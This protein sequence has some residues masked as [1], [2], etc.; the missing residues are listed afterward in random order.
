M[1]MVLMYATCQGCGNQMLLIVMHSKKHLYGPRV[2]QE[3]TA[4]VVVEKLC[5]IDPVHCSNN[6]VIGGINS[7]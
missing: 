1:G 2:R 5:S 7:K 6:I 3:V 4:T